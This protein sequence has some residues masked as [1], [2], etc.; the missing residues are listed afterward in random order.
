M[1]LGNLRRV[2]HRRLQSTEDGEVDYK[3]AVLKKKDIYTHIYIYISECTL[4]YS[5]VLF[6]LYVYLLQLWIHCFEANQSTDKEL[7]ELTL[8][9]A[10]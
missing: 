5:V 2:A 3:K 4:R 10:L 8:I 1:S 7:L 9:V 6:C